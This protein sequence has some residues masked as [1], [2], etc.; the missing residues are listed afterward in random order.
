MSFFYKL[1]ELE[2]NVLLQK[3]EFFADDYLV[4]TFQTIDRSERY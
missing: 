2:V 4:K 3:L 1:T